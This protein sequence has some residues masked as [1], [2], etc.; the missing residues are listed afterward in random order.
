MWAACLIALAGVVIFLAGFA[1]M[2]KMMV[3]G[4][5]IAL[6]AIIPLALVFTYSFNVPSFVVASRAKTW[7]PFGP[8]RITHETNT[9]VTYST[10]GTLQTYSTQTFRIEGTEWRLADHTGDNLAAGDTVI[11]QYLMRD[12]IVRNLKKIETPS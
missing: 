6:L 1:L 3:T 8:S 4:G 5:E 7:L 11:G 10:D 2:A 9:E 12:R